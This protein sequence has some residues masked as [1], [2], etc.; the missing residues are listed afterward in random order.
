MHREYGS[1]G[2]YLQHENYNIEKSG[3]GSRIIYEM[4]PENNCRLEIH[5]P[6]IN[7]Q[8]SWFST[9]GRSNGLEPD[10]NG[11]VKIRPNINIPIISFYSLKG[12][13]TCTIAFSD[14]LNPMD[15]SYGVSEEDKEIILKVKRRSLVSFNILV[16]TGSE[17]VDEA[18]LS[19][20]TWINS[21]YKSHEIPRGA[22]CIVYSTWYSMHQDVDQEVV[23]E[24]ARI[25]RD[26]GFESIFLDDGWQTSD[27]R[28]GYTFTGDWEFEKTKFP[29]PSGHVRRIHEM[30]LNYVI[31]I[32]LP[33]IGM[34]SRAFSKFSSRLLRINEGWGTGIVNPAEEETTEYVKGR[35][36]YLSELG[37]DGL[38]VDFIDSIIDPEDRDEVYTN[39]PEFIER[40]LSPAR[41]KLIEFRQR[42]VSP[43][44]LQHANMIRSSDCPGDHVENR[45]RSLSTRIIS[46]TVLVHSDPLMWSN[47][48]SREN[49]AFAFVNVLFT[50]PQISVM[51]KEQKS[52]NLVLLNK[53]ISFWKEHRSTLLHGMISI[54]HMELNYAVVTSSGKGERITVC[55]SP[56][57]LTS[58]GIKEIII[59][60]SGSDIIIECHKECEYVIRD[61]NFD[62]VR[63]GKLSNGINKVSS[64]FFGQIYI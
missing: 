42:Y 52:E 62:V 40:T 21:Y 64:P 47:E 56:V 5:I 28:R 26:L 44:M 49:I 34:E 45:I 8:F 35:V 55:Y 18:L 16:D 20:S 9:S 24:E 1:D 27:N 36:R 38:K 60:A 61:C 46:G 48:D 19:A 33:F 63:S 39:I 59:N 51:L 17:Y 57:Q 12:F 13:N 22:E 50:V 29:D 41:G 10:W 2:V 43:L 7:I 37:F 32:A 53:W 25:A 4:K 31:W 23:E 58:D 30:G 54:R 6:L 14:C 15:L 3:K 11:Q